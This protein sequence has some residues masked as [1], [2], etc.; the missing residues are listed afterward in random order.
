MADKTPVR[1]VFNA[2]DVAT[3]LAEFQSGES[4][5]TAFGGTGLTSIGSAGQILKVNAAGSA[6]EFAAEGDVSI[7]NL[8][9][10]TNA[11]LTFTTSG[12]GNIVLDAITVRGTTLS[13]ADSSTININEGLIVDGTLNIS[14]QATLS[15]LAFPTSD[16]SANQFLKTDGSGTLSFADVSLG[17]FSFIGSTIST[18]SNAD[19]TLSPS[20][21][22]GVI[23]SGVTIRGTS[24]SS[25]DST[26]INFTDNIVIDGNLT[27]EG[28]LDFQDQNINNV[29]SLSLD[30]ISGDADSNTSITFS[31]SDVITVATGGSTAATFNADQSVTVSG[32][33]VA[34]TSINIASDGATVTGIKD[35]D[36]MASDSNVKLATQQSIKAFVESGTS[37]LTNKT[38]TS[39]TINGATINGGTFSGTFTGDINPGTVTTNNIVSN[40]SNADI[41]LDPTGTGAIK[42]DA[43]TT[44]TTT[45][46]DDSLLVTTTEASNSAAP[47]V[48]LKRDSSSPANADYLGRIKF[49]GENDADQ[50]VQY[51]SISGKIIDVADGS[52]DGA[53][54][55]NVKKAG[56]NNIAARLSSTELKL[57]NG[58]TLDVDG[59]GTFAGVVTATSVTANDLTSNGSNADITIAPQGTGDINLTAGADVNIPA[60]IGITFGDDGEKIEGDGTDLTIN[61]SGDVIMKLNGEQLI[62]HDGSS[63]IAQLDLTSNNFNITALVNDKDMIFKGFD[64]GSTITA[65]T[66]DM[67]EA[68][69][70]IF[71][72]TVTATDITANSL[73]TNVISSN[74]SN[75][76]LSL[77]PSG[78]G[79][80]VISS[81]RVNGTTLDS[82]DSSKVTIAEAVDVT[83]A[84][85]FSGLA[86]PTSDGTS[87]QA[88]V[89]DGSGS[90]SFGTV[91]GK[92][93]SDDGAALVITDKRITSTAR[94]VD[95]F[96]NTFQDSVLYY[97]V[98]NDHFEDLVNVQKVSVAHNNTGAFVSSAGLQSKAS[99]TMTAFTV[100]LDN[101]MIRL[102]AAS[103]NAVGGTLSFYKI[104]LGD[105]TSAGTS[106]NVIITQN[107]D[108]DSASESIVSFAHATFRGAKL[109]VSVNNDSKTEISNFEALVVHDGSEAFITQ[110]G[111]ISSGSNEL[112]TLTAAISGDNVVISGAGLEP[113]LRVTVHAIMLKDSMTSNDGTFDNAEAFAAVTVSSTATEVD[114]LAENTN[115]GAVYYVV[116]KNATEGEYAVNEVFL[117][118]GSGEITVASA[119]FVSTKGT[120]QLTFTSDYKDDNEN[121]G[122][123]L[124]SSTSGGSTTVSGYRINLLAK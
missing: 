24:I 38:L 45:T 2:S 30:S 54:E 107:T 4:I 49:K 12:T 31:G 33:L 23:A 88:I 102:K 10:P 57:L 124:A 47:V 116:S 85:T 27:V 70:A 8:V 73:T 120:N 98:S 36:D 117:A 74:G 80:V 84:L 96:H 40:G 58:T 7:T 46:T 119:G 3:G 109:F 51:A 59:A 43:G 13:A 94:T 97:V 118:M 50:E 68:G 76:D 87:G 62:L 11:D 67:S 69:A 90:L 37:T 108:V 81:L 34:S 79:D 93:A 115:N 25:A 21:T 41:N 22:G 95:V 64:G 104:G 52:E 89:T 83:G 1:V 78:T 48:T 53:V 82:A 111:G 100:G 15:G 72:S 19:L 26:T 29:G 60:N 14:G 6:L 114:T 113:N 44:I 56:T 103:S 86:L 101:D 65:L 18:P 121:L 91:S 106:G 63:N 9:A 20:G 77:Q 122:Q 35:E 66:L 75:A 112:L 42:L 28:T 5:G 99:T 55:F 71:N 123:L 92:S 61:S 17:D 105:N 110:F 39:P 32:A 16:G